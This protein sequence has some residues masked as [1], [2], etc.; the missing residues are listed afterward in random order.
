MHITNQKLIKKKSLKYKINRKKKKK[1]KEPEHHSE[2]TIWR[3]RIDR[4]I[5]R[6]NICHFPWCYQCISG[7]RFEEHRKNLFSWVLRAARGCKCSPMVNT[8]S[9]ETY[10]SHVIKAQI[11]VNLPRC[12]LSV[13]I[14]DIHST[15]FPLFR[16]CLHFWE[17]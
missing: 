10:K 15:I 1:K 14:L 6:G 3:S 11:V 12:L 2:A 4:A 17:T 7:R 13:G 9:L 5:L 16:K 8:V